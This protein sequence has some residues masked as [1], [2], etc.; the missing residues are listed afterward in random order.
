VSD[1]QPVL[2]KDE[3]RSLAAILAPLTLARLVLNGLR[4]FPYTVTTP[5]A[6]ALGVPRA[7]LEQLLSLQFMIGLLSPFVGP[8]IDRGRKRVMLW[9][10]GLMVVGS[11]IAAAGQTFAAVAVAIL[12]GSIA[13]TLYDPAMLAYLGDHVPFARRGFAIGVSELAWSGSLVTLVA[14]SAFLIVSFGL[15]SIF[16]TLAVLGSLAW[17]MLFFL[18]PSDRTNTTVAREHIDLRSAFGL[19]RGNR[20]ALVILLAGFLN[21]VG[22]DQF[23][24]VYEVFLRER[25]GLDTLTIGS[26]SW[27]FGIAEF[28]GEMVIVL[29][30]D[31][32]GKHRLAILAP[33]TL[34]LVFFALRV[35]AGISPT[36]GVV[37]LFALFFAFEITTIS[38]TPLATE[39]IPAARGVM[40]TLYISAISLGRGV[41]NLIGGGIYRAAGV[42]TNLMLAGLFFVGIAVLV[43]FAYRKD[44]AN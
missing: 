31:R 9:M 19:I 21:A 34:A 33:L 12:C 23:L 27:A 41:G 43:I 25:L 30:A 11:I 14:L 35:T 6:T 44:R 36:A 37:T 2:I 32:F 20:A 17:V 7:S 22:F 15:P 40:L 18:L 24:I 38:L 3:D 4:R 42:E 10:I 39:A 13:K 1:A 26:L 8:I 5:M 16:I 28:G 29:L